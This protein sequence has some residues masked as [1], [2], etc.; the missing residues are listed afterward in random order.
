MPDAVALGWVDDMPTLLRA[1][2]VVVQNAGGLSVYEARATRLPVFTYRC[3][4]GHGRMNAAALH[5]AG[6]AEWITYPEDLEKALT[7]TR[8]SPHGAVPQTDPVA[9]VTALLPARV[10]L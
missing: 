6:V 8:H 9:V 5:R 7:T 4:A 10:L 3:L 2:D 1:A